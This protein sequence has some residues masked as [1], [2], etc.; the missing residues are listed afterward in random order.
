MRGTPTRIQTSVRFITWTPPQLG[1]LKLNVDGAS[2]GKPGQ[3]RRGGILRDYC[4]HKIF[5]FPHFYNVHTNT[6]AEA[7]GDPGWL[8]PL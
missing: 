5:A 6:T 4:G 8:A 2:R 1:H 3:A 7:K